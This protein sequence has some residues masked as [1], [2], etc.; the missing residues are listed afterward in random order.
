[1]NAM[2]FDKIA[3]A[4]SQQEQLPLPRMASPCP[5]NA[6]A[7][8]ATGHDGAKYVS[9][10]FE[11]ANGTTQYFLPPDQAKMLGQGIVNAAARQSTSIDLPPGVMLD[12]PSSNG[13]GTDG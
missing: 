12:I 4:A 8:E 6:F 5:A 13:D 10:I 1:M 3:A 9:L 7:A 11:S 2:D